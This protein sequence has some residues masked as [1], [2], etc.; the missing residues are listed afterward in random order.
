MVLHLQKALPTDALISPL[1]RLDPLTEDGQ[2]NLLTNQVGVGS[3]LDQVCMDVPVAKLPDQS[4]LNDFL[5]GSLV[6]RYVQSRLL[7][8]GATFTGK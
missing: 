2:T 7:R 4:L 3:K 5:V 1:D 8:Q 6:I